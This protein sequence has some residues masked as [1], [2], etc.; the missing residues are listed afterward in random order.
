MGEEIL[1]YH[2]SKFVF[3]R[4][5]DFLSSK[6]NNEFVLLRNQRVEICPLLE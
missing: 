2:A 4:T 6:L 1:E 3:D 5:V